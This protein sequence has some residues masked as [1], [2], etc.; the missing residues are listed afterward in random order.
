MQRT[1]RTEKV[2]LDYGR[3]S[4]KRQQPIQIAYALIESLQSP[5]VKQWP[6]QSP[7]SQKGSRNQQIANS[8][9]PILDLLQLESKSVCA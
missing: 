8:K 4:E 3:V 6:K 2:V 9:E 1:T 5:A 7:S